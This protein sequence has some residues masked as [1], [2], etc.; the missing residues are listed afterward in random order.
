M[1]TVRRQ[2]TPILEHLAWILLLL[3][4]AVSNAQTD[5]L[6]S[7]SPVD[8][9]PPSI[10]SAQDLIQKFTA[11]EDKVRD[12]R[13]QYT[14]TRDVLVQTLNDKTPDGQWHEVAQISYDQK[15]K[16]LEKVMFSEVSTLRGIQLSEE[17][18]DDIRTFMPWL[19]TS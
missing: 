15:G 4:A 6:D 17:D 13:S 14:L 12:A 3:S 8:S 9:A 2:T 19:F 10:M 7:D 1:A 18:K 5:C 11:S 16:P